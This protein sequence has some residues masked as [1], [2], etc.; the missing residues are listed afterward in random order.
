MRN[1]FLVALFILISC[2]QCFA[3][4]SFDQIQ[5]LIKEQKYAA[6]SAGLEGIIKNHPNSAKAYYA[7]SQAQAGLGNQARAQEALD[8]A[9]GLDPTLKF[10]PASNVKN[11]QQALAPQTNKI[12]AI[13]S[14][15]WR[16]ILIG[17]LLFGGIAAFFAF[18]NKKRKIEEPI[19]TYPPMESDALRVPARSRAYI[20]DRNDDPVPPLRPRNIPPSHQHVAP[21][22]HHTTVVNN[23][24]S[25]D[26]LTGVL[27]GSM[28]SQHGGH[29]D[30]HSHHE[31]SRDDAQSVAR[32]I[33]DEP[34][35]SDSSWD[36][37]KVSKSDSSWDDSASS[38]SSD[39]SWGSDSS[40]SSSD[41]SSSSSS[42]SSS[43][44]SWD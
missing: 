11:L 29:S 19:S 1:V 43:S 22:Q 5:G 42:D 20:A 9:T 27:V 13:E 14:H 40:S 28:L 2:T 12:Q 15:L 8:R 31:S 16:N 41:S 32:H 17:L 36:E 4:A 6:A 25:A 18:R 24:G 3:E 7:M 26:M 35:K 30:H 37:D 34:E 23:G 39:S 33:A 44:S 38:S 10:A 21:I